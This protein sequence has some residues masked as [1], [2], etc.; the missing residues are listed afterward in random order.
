MTIKT[1]IIEKFIDE[2]RSQQSTYKEFG[3]TVR[4]IVKPI[5][6]NN[7]FG[8]QG[9]SYRAKGI[10]SLRKKIIKDKRYQELKTISEI[11]DLVGCRIIFYLD[12]DIERFRNHIY[13]EFNVI[14]EELKYS[15]DEYNAL[16]FVVALNEDRLKLMEYAKYSN[17]KCEIQLTTALYHAWS[18]MNHDIIYKP[19]KELSNFDKQTFSSLKKEFSDVMKNHIKEAQHTFDF[20]SHKVE[21]I[22]QGKQ[23]FDTKFLNNIIHSESNNEL[24]KN[25][26]LLHK[27][28]RE[29]GDKT[30]KEL[31]IIKIIESALEK[32]KPLK[33]RPIKMTIGHLKGYTYADV[34]DVCL[35]ILD[36]IRYFYPEKV[37]NLLIILSLDKE[38]E[39]KKKS[40]EILSRLSQYNINVLKKIGY[41]PQLLI[42]GKIEKWGTEQLIKRIES[43]TVIS[44]KLLSPSFEGITMKDYKTVA[45]QFGALKADDNLKKIRNRTIAMLK[46]LYVVVKDGEQKQKIIQAFQE[47]TRMPDRSDYDKDMENMV[48]DNTNKL[49]NYYISILPNADNAII[50]DI[51]EDVYWLT[52]S[53]DANKIPRV[54]ELQ[55]LIRSKKDY[56]IFKTFVGYHYYETEI[57]KI[58]SEKVDWKEKEERRRN[59]IK[60]FVD[61]ISEKNFKD[62]EQKILSIIKNYSFSEDQGKFWHFNFFL[63]ELGN[64]KPEIAYKLL[65]ENEEK[66]KPFLT[67]LIAGIWESKLKQSVKELIFKWVNEGKHLSQCAL[68][69]N[70]VGEIDKLL[71]NKIFNQAIKI[72]DKDIQN[73]TFNNI[74]QSI[75]TNYP[76]HKYTKNLFIN[77]IKGLT[78]NKN[79][80]WIYNEWYSRGSILKS[81]TNTQVDTILKNLL[82]LPNI[83]YPAEEAL[84]QIAE[85]YPQ[86][87]IDFFYKRIL[88]QKKKKREDHYDAI[89]YNLHQMNKSLSEKAVIT[90]PEILKW[91]NKEEDS[92]YWEGTRLIAAIFP[93]FNKILEKELIKLIKSK[94]NKKVE[95]VFNI[96]LAYEGEDFLHNVCKELIKEYPKNE[97]YRNKIFTVLSQ[98]GVVS[99]EYGFVEGFKKKKEEIQSWKKDKNKAI[100]LFVKEY[101]D[102]LDKR[103]LYEKKQADE[104]IEL[105]KRQ[106]DS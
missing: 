100:Q 81:L 97:D 78:K 75:V 61:D 50:K 21:N 25:L 43:I 91:F 106:F 14:K 15:E 8:H 52:R 96:L 28:I 72:K 77:S 35:E 95:I 86:K 30:P 44:K 74:I 11:N 23:V 41:Y 46:K 27:Y 104:V 93:N 85:N 45:F 90:V 53:L 3:K 62:W 9:V 42:L 1:D 82:H 58:E 24:Y 31:N 39:V 48:L 54:K 88:I 57:E 66:L 103:I 73:N 4:K 105:R 67:R 99:G 56:D 89:P 26:T 19:Q 36:D 79:W 12:R 83:K 59:K 70:Y 76:K 22:K 84:A 63:N 17:M 32:S 98:I 80:N 10:N 33:I 94:N 68:V 71:I 13:K 2:Y 49:I 16:H 64:Q 18:E 37:F 55:S 7:E 38:P 6:K 20:I 51:E 29:F 40:L 47:S 60:E 92:L 101:E 5:L 34:A 102:F 65:I 69:F 87:I